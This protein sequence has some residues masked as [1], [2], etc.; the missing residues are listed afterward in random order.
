MNRNSHPIHE[1]RL[2]TIRA[3]IWANVSREQRTFFNVS[4]SR[5]Y[6]D[7][8]QWK[9]SH[10]FGRDDLPVLAKV[11]ELAYAWIWNQS[12]LAHTER[13]APRNGTGA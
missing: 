1:I 9:D 4:V 8:E 7:G 2:G 11:V 6:R 3:C 5:L 13:P 12:P 10:S